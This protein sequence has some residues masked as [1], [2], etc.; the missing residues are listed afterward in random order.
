MACDYAFRLGVSLEMGISLKWIESLIEHRDFQLCYTSVVHIWHTTD[1]GDTGMAVATAPVEVFCCYSH[2]DELWLRKLETHV[3][4]LQRQGLVSLWN[5]RR[6]VP[7]DVWVKTIDVHLEMASVILLLV[8]ADFLASDYCYS[9]EMKRA[10]ERQEA[11]EARV[12]PILVRPV[13][14]TG[15]P[16]AHLQVLPTDAKPIVSW[17]DKNTAL[18]DVAAGIRRVIVEELPQLTAS[19]PRAALPAI[20][21]IPYPRNPFFLGRDTEL[22]H[23]HQNLQTGQATALSQPQAISGLG[24]I[25]KTQ[26]A[27]EYAYRFHQDY[28]AILWARAESIEALISSYVAIASLLQLP[29]REARKQEIIVQDVKAWLQMHRGWLLILDNADELAMLPGFLP[30]SLGGH[31]LLTTRAAATGRLAQRMEIETL[32]P[33]QGALFLLR[34]AGL[35]TPDAELLQVSQEERELAVQIS[36]E[37]GGLPLALD[38]AGAYLEET[39]TGLAS[40]WQIYQQHRA[41]LLRERRGFVTD[42]PEPVASTWSLSFQQIEERNTAASDLLRLFAYL[43][44]DAIPEEIITIGA[45]SLGPALSPVA[46]D[47]FLLN[48]ALEA[49]RAYSLIRRDPAKKLLSIH[50][51]VQAVLQDAMEE[52]ERRIWAQRVTLALNAAFPEDNSLNWQQCERLL[53]Q[54]VGIMQ[55][56]E[57]Y[58]IIGEEAGNL[59]Y[60]AAHYLF[61]HSRFVEAEP[62][63]RCALQIREQRSRPLDPF[64]ADSLSR[65]ANL[66]CIQGNYADK[67]ASVGYARASAI[68]EQTLGVQHPKT[69]ETRKHLVALLHTLGQHEE[70]AL[71]EGAQSEQ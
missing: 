71:L 1:R 62:L 15:A 29:E 24:G 41:R 30:P 3:S 5:D 31:L 39:G 54:A 7:G 52:T 70:A 66:Y 56:I 44:P 40:Y 46:A 63:Y 36:Q 22:L 4:V 65:L 10:L 67:E 38:Q 35:L 18:A 60:N 49:L 20:W 6:I 2:K 47:T 9:V 53:S 26:L 57:R 34:R 64:V 59:L 21:N 17:P 51:L 55:V 45:S 58:N 8:S 50:R 32:L 61:N 23:I 28:Q 48:Q 12:I 42:Y 27:L 25:G 68:H 14:W 43:S 16:F 19:A 69:R 11:G 33:E 37:L 13:D